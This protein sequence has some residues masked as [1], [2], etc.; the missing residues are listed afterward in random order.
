MPASP[1]DAG[2][3]RPRRG[4]ILVTRDDRGRVLLV[5]QRGGP[6]KSAWLLP[7]GGVEPG[8]SF[9]DAMRREVREET[10]LE[11]G[12]ARAIALYDVR[13][14][15]FHGEVQ[16]YA[17]DASGVASVGLDGEP[18]EWAEIDT[19]TA[20]PVLLREICDAGVVPGP[21]DLDARLAALGIR[22]TRV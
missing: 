21:A 12:E 10:C 8:E 4:A 9:E 13:V 6:F 5:R 7:G 22:M 20:H 3:E 16:L 15:D 2:G 18:I 1:A 17:G 11:V 19:E 14:G